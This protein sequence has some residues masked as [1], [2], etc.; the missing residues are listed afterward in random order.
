MP[1]LATYIIP[2]SSTKLYQIGSAILGW[3]V[4][5]ERAV[6]L[7]KELQAIGSE[8]ELWRGP[9]GKFGFHATIGDAL[10]YAAEMVPEIEVRLERIARSTH[11]FEL[12]NGRVH[13]SFRAV[14]RCLAATFDSP[15]QAVNQLEERVVTEVNVLHESS[16]WFGDFQDRF[17]PL[18]LAQFRG[19]GSPNVRSLFD[20]HFTLASE[21]PDANTW[22]LL[23]DLVRCGAGFL[24]SEDQRAM[25]VDRIFLLEEGEDGQ[26][27]VR[28]SFVLTGGVG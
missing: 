14:P 5:A 10:D 22:R 1:R 8:L 26:Y 7:P 28:R 2:E 12:S 27:R 3:D 21:I 24:E 25:T 16:P 23:K 11:P 13:T 6:P 20:L 15:G 4:I 17:T 18:Q 9:A 19:F